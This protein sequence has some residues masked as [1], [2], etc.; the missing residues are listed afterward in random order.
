[1]LTYIHIFL[2]PEKYHELHGY[3]SRAPFNTV[4]LAKAVDKTLKAC[5]W[6]HVYYMTLI[7]SIKKLD[8]GSD[9]TNCI[10]MA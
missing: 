4:K 8:I 10:V 9:R 6:S 2:H 3:I 7:K 1:M 5:L